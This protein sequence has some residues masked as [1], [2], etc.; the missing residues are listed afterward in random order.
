MSGMD[1]SIGGHEGEGG[2]FFEDLSVGMSASFTRTVTEA[3]IVLFAAVSGDLNPIHVNEEY[4][5]ETMFKGRIAHG[6]LTAGLISAILGNQLPGHGCVYLSQTLTFL[7]PVKA[8]DT[9]HARATVTEVV[10]QKKWAV[11]KT[12]CFVDNTQV[13]D[14]EAVVL[15]PSRSDRPGA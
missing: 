1:T 11:L 13:L 15:V 5:R 8:G 2:Y 6:I 4:A 14:G 12:E 3:D 10:P 7:A 9:V